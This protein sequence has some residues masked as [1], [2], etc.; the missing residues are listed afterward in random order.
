VRR[1]WKVVPA[2]VAAAALLPAAA[3]A[4]GSPPAPASDDVDVITP[5]Y[6]TPMPQVPV[7]GVLGAQKT[8]RA[9]DARG[10]LA[11]GGSLVGRVEGTGSEAGHL[12]Y[13]DRG[14]GI[15]LGS[16]FIVSLRFA[17]RGATITGVAKNR[18]VP[19]SFTVTAQRGGRLSI[20]LSNGYA[21][22]GVLQGRLVVG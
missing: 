7:G 6:F 10:K 16:T 3:N 13:V 12:S 20:A 9:V 19:V 17:R 1:L 2:L 5:D 22:S 18:G 21:R 15:D 4:N 11:N 8:I 14:A